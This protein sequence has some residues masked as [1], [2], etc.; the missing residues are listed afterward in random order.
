MFRAMLQE[1]KQLAGSLRLRGIVFPVPGRELQEMEGSLSRLGFVRI[2]DGNIVYRIAREQLSRSSLLLLNTK[3][4][5]RLVCS[6]SELTI[7]ESTAFF[8]EFGKRFPRSFDPRLLDGALQK[9]HSF[10]LRQ[11]GRI[12]GFLLSTAVPGNILYLASF[13]FLET[14][15]YFA[16]VL[17]KHWLQSLLPE[18]QVSSQESL[19]TPDTVLFSAASMPAEKLA[20][21]LLK[22]CGSSVEREVIQNYYLRA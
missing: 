17:L 6:L 5:D 7:E 22:D 14:K 13:Y 21:H 15:R 11:N 12:D 10:V 18:S 4:R 2:S 19:D 16:P 3:N 20:R 1:A 8:Q 9:E